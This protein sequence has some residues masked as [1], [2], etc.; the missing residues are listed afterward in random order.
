MNRLAFESALRRVCG[1]DTTLLDRV[2]YKGTRKSI[3][4][5][6]LG[7]QYVDK[8]LVV[9]DGMLHDIVEANHRFTWKNICRPSI[10]MIL[11]EI[12][13]TLK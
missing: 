7:P 12:I 6:T 9:I 1:N 13:K 10:K 4:V 5:T 2:T 3:K 8:H 11:E